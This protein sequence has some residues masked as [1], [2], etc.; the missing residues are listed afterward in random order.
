MKPKIFETA[1]NK[2]IEQYYK[3]KKKKRMAKERK[4]KVEVITAGEILPMLG[5]TNNFKNASKYAKQLSDLHRF[6]CSTSSLKVSAEIAERGIAVTKEGCIATVDEMKDDYVDLKMDWFEKQDESLRDLNIQVKELYKVDL[7][8]GNRIGELRKKS[9]K[10][11]VSDKKKEEFA[12]EAKEIEVKRDDI[13]KQVNELH[14]NI[15]DIKEVHQKE[16]SEK[17]YDAEFLRT[18]LNLFAGVRICLELK[19][20]TY[21]FVLP[22]Q[23]SFYQKI[24][25]LLGIVDAGT[26]KEK[27]V[28]KKVFTMPAEVIEVIKAA[29][30]YAS[31]DDLRPSMT[32]VLIEIV[33]NKLCVVATDAHVLY[34]SR[35]F[36]ISGPPGK[37]EYILPAK[38]LLKLPKVTD[39]SV[40]L[41]ELKDGSIGLLNRTISPIDARFPDYKAVIPKYDKGIEFE[42]EDF[43]RCVKQVMPYTNKST[44][45]V[46]LTLNGDITMVAQDVDFSFEGDIR[47]RY[48]KKEIEDMEIAFNGRYLIQCANTFNSDTITMLTDCESHHAGIFTD[49]MDTVLVMPLMLHQ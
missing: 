4:P 2:A 38:K 5:L 40:M 25:T 48:M 15:S 10:K 41:Y 3:P 46:K 9:K 7:L 19:T 43:V 27:P 11:D 36:T 32:G 8:H 45:S 12:A 34:S 20:G 23:N 47:M 21:K 30:P 44:G 22:T 37:Y 26:V 1:R 24:C 31:G 14:K 6:I 28:I 49:G 33:N 35:W 17:Q 18:E 29:L 13:S 42:R 16:L 39:E